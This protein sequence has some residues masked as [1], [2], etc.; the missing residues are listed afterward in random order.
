MNEES[1]MSEPQPSADAPRYLSPQ[2][3]AEYLRMSLSWVRKATRAGKLPHIPLGWRIV[4]DRVDLDRLMEDLKRAA[5]WE[6]RDSRPRRRTRRTLA[7]SVAAPERTTTLPD[8]A[9][10]SASAT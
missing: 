1:T 8:A 7:P 4:Y 10:P 3:A 2:E 5:A 6:V 9:A